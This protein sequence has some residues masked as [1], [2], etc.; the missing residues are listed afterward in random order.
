[1]HSSFELSCKNA[2]DAIAVPA[3]PLD[4]IRYG[5][6]NSRN[7]SAGRRRRRVV[8]AA[9]ASLSLVAVAAAAEMFGHVQVSLNPSGEVHLSF[10]GVNGR[11]TQFRDPKGSDIQKAARAMNFPVILPKGLPAGTDAEAVTVLGPGAMQIVYNLPGAW[12]RSNHLLFVILANPKS[13]APDDATP[14]KSKFSMQFGQ[15]TGLGAVRWIVGGEE[16]IVLKSTITAAE[17]AHFK[18]VMT[19]RA[20]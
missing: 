4:A 17:L 10:D 8:A 3:I 18:A 5:A 6:H 14:P 19:A 16:V 12:R 7:A 20:H 1:M 11:L 13:V 9:V 2:R 15:K